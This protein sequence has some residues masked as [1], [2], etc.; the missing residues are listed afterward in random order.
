M[1]IVLGIAFVVH[2]MIHLLYAAHS[3]RLF[4]LQPGMSWPDGS[5]AF[6]SLLGN[7]TTRNLASGAFILAAAGFVAAGIALFATQPWWRP[8]AL[9]SAA[10]STLMLLLLWNGKL[11]ALTDQGLIAVFINIAILVAL[12]VFQWPRLGF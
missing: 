3:A 11:H 12:L 6:S 4:E 1:K 9:G 2:G 7:E 5:W 10:F 8:V